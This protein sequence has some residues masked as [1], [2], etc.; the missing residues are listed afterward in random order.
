MKL[1]AFLTFFV[2]KLVTIGATIPARTFM[3]LIYIENSA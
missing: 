3:V 2:H 1:G